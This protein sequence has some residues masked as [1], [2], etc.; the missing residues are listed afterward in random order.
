[1]AFDENLAS[2]IRAVLSAQPGI[3]EK[4]MFGGIAFLRNGLMFVG[5][6]GNTLMARVGKANYED[7]LARKHVRVMDF[8]GKPMA[9]YVFVDAE[10]TNT[11]DELAFWVNRS[12]SF[13]ATLPPKDAKPHKASPRKAKRAA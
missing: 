13:V 2:R 9:G 10:G 8:T 5:V 7:S 12:A 1:M 11:K 6:S 3:T 4:R